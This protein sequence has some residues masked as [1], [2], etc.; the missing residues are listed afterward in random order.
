MPQPWQYPAGR[1]YWCV[2]RSVIPQTGHGQR[3]L[4]GP[5]PGRGLGHGGI[6]RAED[7]GASVGLTQRFL[8]E[9]QSGAPD[10]E[11]SDMSKIGYVGTHRS[12]FDAASPGDRSVP[13]MGEPIFRRS[14]WPD[15]EDRCRE[16]S[17]RDV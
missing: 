17:P 15:Q 3:Y 14:M 2:G 6:Q 5:G 4:T 16:A 1:E 13:T 9:G 10:A 12:V 7:T 8:N 11:P